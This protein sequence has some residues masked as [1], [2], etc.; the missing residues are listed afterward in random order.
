MAH[1]DLINVVLWGLRL[2]SEGLVD[3]VDGWAYHVELVYTGMC[4]KVVIEVDAASNLCEEFGAHEVSHL[5]YSGVCGPIVVQGGTL[6]NPHVQEDGHKVEDLCAI[7]GEVHTDVFLGSIKVSLVHCM[8]DKILHEEPGEV[9]IR[10]K[11]Q[12]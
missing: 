12:G 3:V 4:L 5:G 1:H 2:S 8:V 7:C 11:F 10:R 6:H 9:S